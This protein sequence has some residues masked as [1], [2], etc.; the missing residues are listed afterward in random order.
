MGVWLLFVR[1]SA[2]FDNSASS[3]SAAPRAILLPQWRVLLYIA[4][5]QSPKDFEVAKRDDLIQAVMDVYGL[6]D[7]GKPLWYLIPRNWD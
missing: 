6:Q 4:R 1:F 2:Q 5:N 3:E 7:K